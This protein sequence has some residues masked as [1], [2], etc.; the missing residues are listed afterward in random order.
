VHCI[1]RKSCRI[2]FEWDKAKADANEAKHR[3]PFEVARRVFDDDAYVVLEDLRQDYGERR[4]VALGTI[5]NRIYT[6]AF[7]WRGGICRL[8]SASKANAREIRRYHRQD[9]T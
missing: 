6:V 8:I 1:D 2:E 5:D 3:V 7:T 4:F 9:E